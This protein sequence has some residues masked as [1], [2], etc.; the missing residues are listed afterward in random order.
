MLIS[1]DGVRC[2]AVPLGILLDE[3]LGL[4]HVSEDLEILVVASINILTINLISCVKDVIDSSLLKR[5][6][7]EVNQVE[8]LCIRAEVRVGDESD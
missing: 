8:S 4:R 7:G 6:I 1:C 5:I 2:D 3:I